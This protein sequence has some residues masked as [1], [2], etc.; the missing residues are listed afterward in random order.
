MELVLR[1]LL[2]VFQLGNVLYG[3]ADLRYPVRS[4]DLVEHAE[5]V[6]D[7]CHLRTG[8]LVADHI[9]DIGEGHPLIGDPAHDVLEDHGMLA[10]VLG[11]LSLQ[12]ILLAFGAEESVVVREELLHS[13]HSQRVIRLGQ[14]DEAQEI[15]DLGEIRHRQTVDERQVPAIQC[16][17]DGIGYRFGGAENDGIG[18]RIVLIDEVDGVLRELAVVPDLV[19]DI[20]SV[21]PFLEDVDEFAFRRRAALVQLVEEIHADDGYASLL[22][23]KPRDARI[24]GFEFIHGLLECRKGAIGPVDLL[25]TPGGQIIPDILRVGPYLSEVE[26][27][28]VDMTEAVS[29][30]LGYLRDELEVGHEALSEDHRTELLDDMTGGHGEDPYARLV[31]TGVQRRLQSDI[32]GYDQPIVLHLIVQLVYALDRPHAIAFLSRMQDVKRVL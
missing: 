17:A 5:L 2:V 18:V 10:H 20:Q 15:P 12:Q 6:E 23:E 16:R 30:L 21:L 22:L 9:L 29:C 1:D 26:D 8:L 7:H 3:E 31:D 4:H 13:P 11:T 19:D 28:A 24:V 32:V 25:R 14:G 27:L